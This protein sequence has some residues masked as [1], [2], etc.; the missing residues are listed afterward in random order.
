MGSLLGESIR[1]VFERCC[2][3]ILRE[4]DILS[5]MTCISPR[6]QHGMRLQFRSQWIDLW[7][8]RTTKSN[9]SV[10]RCSRVP[11]SFSTRRRKCIDLSFDRI[12]RLYSIKNPNEIV[13]SSFSHLESS[14]T[15]SLRMKMCWSDRRPGLHDALHSWP[16]DMQPT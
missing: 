2:K 15:L 6:Y 3:D 14:Y 4:I 5:V 9:W 12:V 11:P 8:G 1:T 10:G 13:L 16:R 7:S